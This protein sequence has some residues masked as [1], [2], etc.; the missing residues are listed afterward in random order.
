LFVDIS[1]QSFREIHLW[2][3]HF[4]KNGTGSFMCNCAKF[5]RLWITAGF[6]MTQKTDKGEILEEAELVSPFVEQ[7]PWT[8]TAPPHADKTCGCRKGRI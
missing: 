5:I 7:R 6:T 3:Y 4:Q 8:Q 2:I 1:K